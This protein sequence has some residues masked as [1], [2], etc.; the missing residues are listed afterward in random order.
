MDSRWLF[1]KEVKMNKKIIFIVLHTLSLLIFVSSNL[2]SDIIYD[3]GSEN[4]MYLR[5]L[6][7]QNKFDSAD[8]SYQLGELRLFNDNIERKIIFKRTFDEKEIIQGDSISGIDY[9]LLSHTITDTITIPENSRISYFRQLGVSLSCVY[10]KPMDSARNGYGGEATKWQDYFW[11]AGKNRILDDTEFVLEMVKTLDSSVVLVIDSVGVLKNPNTIIA[12]VYGTNPDKINHLKEIDSSYYGMNVFFRVKVK[13]DGLTP[14]GCTL[15]KIKSWVSL[16]SL[17]EYDSIRSVKSITNEILD[18]IVNEYFN[19]TML[20]CDSVKKATGWLPSYLPDGNVFSSYQDSIFVNTFFKKVFWL[21]DSIIVEKDSVEY[22]SRVTI[23]EPY[24]QNQAEVELI[25]VKSV[26]PQP[27]E[28]DMTLIIK[29]KND[30]SG[31]EI[32]L[33][34]IQG[35]KL[36]SLWTG[37]LYSGQNTIE[38]HN[39]SLTKGIYFLSINYGSYILS[40]IKINKN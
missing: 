8:I 35:R 19:K 39:H 16:S 34:D 2:F 3:I 4:A 1:L 20:Y 26:S 37:N 14:Y 6:Y 11:V 40:R 36:K 21:G 32:F 38:I 27:T 10:D 33:F 15:A 22:A 18:T 5:Y 17:I 13:R 24:I 12:P 9:K 25:K 29:S 28:E 31:I 7:L 30:L 23:H